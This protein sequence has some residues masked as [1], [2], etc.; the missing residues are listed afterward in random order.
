MDKKECINF[1]KTNS[2][3]M[4]YYDQLQLLEQMSRR[5]IK[6]SE[7][8]DGCRIW[9]DR[10]PHSELKSIV[11]YIQSIMLRDDDCYISL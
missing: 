4:Q 9:L 5:N 10:L 3:H 8:S 1:I 2:S 6:I 11:K 7:G